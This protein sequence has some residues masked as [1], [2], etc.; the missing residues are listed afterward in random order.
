MSDSA[1]PWTVARQAPLSVGIT[2]QEYLSGL[3]F[4]PPRDLPHPGVEPA[5]PVAPAL[6]S[7]FFNT[8]APGKS[9]VSS[10]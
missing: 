5:S 6:A 1:T 8:E 9:Q 7:G 4:P 10:P 2:W 3:R